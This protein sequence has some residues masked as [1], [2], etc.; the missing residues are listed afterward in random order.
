MADWLTK[1][2]GMVCPATTSEPPAP[3]DPPSLMDEEHG[4]AYRTVH[5]VCYPPFAHEGAID[6]L[7]GVDWS[8]EGDI[9]IA[10]YP[11]CGTT[12]MQQMVLL[13]LA[14]GDADA[15]GDPMEAAP[16][17]DREFS[18]ATRKARGDEAAVD[19]AF[20]ALVHADGAPNFGGRRCF[21]THAPYALFP[22]GGDFRR[23]KVIVV[24]RN[25]KDACAS[26]YKHYLG[27]P[28]FRY[29]GPWAHFFGLFLDGDVGQGSWFDHVLGWRAAAEPLGDRLLFLSFEDM[30]ADVE[31]SVRRIAAFVDVPLDDALLAKVTAA[32]SFDAMKGQH[33]RRVSTGEQRM[34]SK[35]H[36]RSGTSGGWRSN[37]TVEQ[38]DALDARFRDRM[39]GTDIVTD[40]GKGERYVGSTKVSSI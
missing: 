24:T 35:T 17:V 30:K 38:S 5:G 16:W 2:M 29:T 20:S 31:A 21:K 32:S 39:E 3:A 36:F 9:M 27:L 34:G 6:R 14:G 12:W 1:M 40:F 23:G 25:P 13:L 7:R 37:F 19:A 11:K 26:M 33:A 10:T 28:H 18:I 15:V 22:C 8:R 4:Y